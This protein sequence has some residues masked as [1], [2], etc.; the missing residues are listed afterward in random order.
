MKF[1]SSGLCLLGLGVSSFIPAN[2]GVR[3]PPTTS[4]LVERDF[5]D[6]TNTNTNAFAVHIPDDNEH[7]SARFRVFLNVANPLQATMA[8]ND[9]TQFYSVVLTMARVVW[10]RGTPRTW[11]RAAMGGLVLMFHSDS[12]IPWEFLSAF[13]TTMVSTIYQFTA[14]DLVSG[15]SF[16]LISFLFGKIPCSTFHV[17]IHFVSAMIQIL[18]NDI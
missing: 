12:P 2:D 5:H 18:P 7:W 9:L 3:A 4:V 14:L 15:I 6:T 8:A 17:S 10:A 16:A 1:L 11:R 13:L